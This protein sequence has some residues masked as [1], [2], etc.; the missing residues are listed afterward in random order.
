M[1]INIGRASI[2]A[3]LCKHIACVWCG[4]GKAERKQKLTTPNPSLERRGAL[5][6]QCGNGG[7]MRGQESGAGNFIH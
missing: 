7:M 5:E 6:E 1:F 2:L 4:N 3:C